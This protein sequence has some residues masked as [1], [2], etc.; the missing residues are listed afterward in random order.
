[1]KDLRLSPPAAIQSRWLK[2]NRDQV[3]LDLTRSRDEVP[4]S[5]W[6]K[7]FYVRQGCVWSFLDSRGHEMPRYVSFDISAAGK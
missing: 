6:I 2:H 5:V 1:M 7:G 3:G 4:E